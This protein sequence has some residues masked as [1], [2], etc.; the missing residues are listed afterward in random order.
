MRMA[1]SRRSAIVKLLMEVQSV[2]W[3]ILLFA[4]YCV[5]QWENAQRQTQ[6]D[7]AVKNSS[8]SV[9]ISIV[10]VCVCTHSSKCVMSLHQS[11]ISLV[12]A[13]FSQKHSY[14]LPF[15]GKSCPVLSQAVL[16]RC[17]VKSVYSLQ[18]PWI[19][20]WC[21]SP[22]SVSSNVSSLFKWLL[23]C[24]SIFKEHQMLQ[25]LQVFVFSLWKMYS[26]NQRA[27]FNVE[28]KNRISW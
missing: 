26:W 16:K 10:V 4:L 5:L 28:K 1:T 24:I 15:H 8:L 2:L 23:R 20:V 27:G 17:K 14:H 18:S 13:Q 12:V 6:L 7:A 9:Y 11:A 21:L 25:K 19:R 3:L 22:S